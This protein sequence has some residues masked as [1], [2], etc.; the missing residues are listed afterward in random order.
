MDRPH[1]ITDGCS[2]VYMPDES[3]GATA[4]FATQSP[5][6]SRSIA[7]GNRTSLAYMAPATY[8]VKKMVQVAMMNVR[9]IQRLYSDKAGENHHVPLAP[10]YH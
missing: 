3:L 2:P 8:M 7:V 10:F 1:S 9:K 4:G 6:V 5:E